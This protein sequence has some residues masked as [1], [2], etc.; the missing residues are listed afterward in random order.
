MKAKWELELLQRFTELKREIEEA[1]GIQ[2]YYWTIQLPSL[3]YS[4]A[5]VR[6]YV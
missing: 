1:Y 4:P 6:T 3:E 2:H 5:W